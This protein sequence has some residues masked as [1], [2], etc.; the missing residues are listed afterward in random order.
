[1]AL[2]KYWGADE[3]IKDG[4]F[5]DNVILNNSTGAYSL[6]VSEQM[7]AMLLEL[8]KKLHIYRDNQN[9]RL[10]KSEGR[11]KSI[12]N[13]KVLVVGLGDIG[14][15]FAK[16]IKSFGGYT[17][18]VKRRQTE[19]PS[20]IDELLPE[21]DI[22]ALCIPSTKDTQKLFSKE[23]IGLMKEGSILLNVG[24]GV[25]V[26]TE[27]LSDALESNHLLEAGLDV[28]DPEPRPSDHRIWG[29]QNAVI[30]PHISGWYNLA[31]TYESILE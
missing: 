21:A 3:Y 8:L 22:V 24:R 23:I 13:S 30:T 31:E 11:A 4:V 17:I 25:S 15:N 12:Y 29:L 6:A 16:M 27:T 26:D 5:E 2:I 10:W 9:K 18:G 19:K 14:C 7:L 1:M 28:I 20:F